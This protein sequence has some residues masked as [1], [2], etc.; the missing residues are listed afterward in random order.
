[1]KKTHMET[2]ISEQ[3]EIMEHII[4]R[5]LYDKQTVTM[6]SPDI[7]EKIIL[8]ASGSSYHCARCA[9]EI[10]GDVAQIEARAIYS[11]EFLLKKVVPHD[12]LYIF[13][14]QSGETTDTLSCLNKVQQLGMKTLCVTNVENSTIWNA[15]DYKINCM[16]GTE[17]SIASTKALTAQMLCLYILAIKF[18]LKKGL[19]VSEHIRNLERLPDIIRQTLNLE[20]KIKSLAKFLYKYKDIVIVADGVS[21]ALAK[22]ACLKIKET[23][24]I[25]VMSHVLGEFM[26]GH[27]AVLNNK[28]TVLVYISSEEL[29]YLAIKNLE[30]IKNE[31]NPPICVIG[32]ST[33]RINTSYNVDLE[34]KDEDYIL[35]LFSNL[36]IIQ[37][38]ALRI[39]EKLGRNVDRPK[40]LHKIVTEV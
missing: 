19:K 36:V 30:K 29:S 20:L 13:I 22:E 32:K 33:N 14:T 6:D 7:A 3:P 21:Y 28:K 12:V 18:A 17:N 34:I 26:H 16:A 27:L 24:Y 35:K 40:G 25:N 11:S 10:F 38:L 23:S 5:Y 4:E 9:A 37:I 1:M 2:E 31:Y 8:V 15:A 39:A